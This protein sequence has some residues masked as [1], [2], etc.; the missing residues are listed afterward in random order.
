VRIGVPR[1]TK[2]GELRVALLPG[3]VRTLIAQGHEV[4]VQSQAGTGVGHGDEAYS[5]QGASNG[6][7]FQAWDCELVVKV[8]EMLP[9]D[10]RHLRPTRAIFC[11]HQLPSEPER[12]RA[13]AER[14]ATAIAFEMVRDAAGGFP[15]LAPMSV[16][17]G[18]MAVE[19]VSRFLP[20]QGGR[21]LVLG[22][23]NA[24]LSAART[25]RDRGLAVK[26]LTRSE[27]SRDR[28]RAEGLDAG[29]ATA[30]AVEEMAVASDLVVGAALVAGLPT[31]RLLSRALVRRMKRGAVIADISID[32]GGVAETSRATTQAEPFFEEEGV[33]HYCVSNIPGA[34]PV[35]ATTA[36]SS[37]LVPLVS[38]LAT[39]GLAA[40]LRE[41]PGLREGLLLWKGQVLHP[42]IAKSAGLPYTRLS[43]EDLT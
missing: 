8:K 28:A 11:F 5:R 14:G 17:S 37:A 31:P 6:T 20:V 1:E 22:A 21:A 30:E 24:G 13:L 27:P 12:T 41:N 3:D 43:P 29:I 4:V 34:D 15:L 19:A 2:Q 7:A 10:L 36:L 26:V 25:A 9:E 23:G 16:I 35:A 32:A 38:E 39:R 33:V 18:R 42:G 40:A